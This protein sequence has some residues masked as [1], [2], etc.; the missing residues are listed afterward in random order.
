MI[1][2]SANVVM[3]Q[4]RLSCEAL[5]ESGAERWGMSEARD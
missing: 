3:V 5:D 1:A 2:S 4:A